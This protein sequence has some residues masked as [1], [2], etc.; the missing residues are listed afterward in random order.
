MPVVKVIDLVS[1]SPKGW[2][3]AVENAVKEAAKTIRNIRRAYVQRLICKIRDGE[4][5]EYRASV[6]IAF[7]VEEAR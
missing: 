4:I 6:R 3:E 2:Q 5:V 1:G 7:E